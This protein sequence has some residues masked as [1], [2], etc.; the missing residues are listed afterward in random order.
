MSAVGRPEKLREHGTR[1]CCKFGPRPGGD[2][3]NGC[4]CERC[5]KANRDAESERRRLTAYG[6]WQPYIDAGPAR[7][8]LRAL[9]ASGI[10]WKQAARL[11]GVSTG[12]VS[13]ILYGG[14]GGRPPSRR[15]RPATAAAILSVVPS[16]AKLA[17]SSRVDATGTRRRVQALV[18]AGW[19]QSKISARLGMDRA[20]FGAVMRQD[21]VTAST[22][23]AVAALY[24]EL[25]DKGPPEQ[26]H[27]DKI[28]ASR[29]R[30]YS[31]ERG[32]PP[33]AAWDDDID[34]PMAVPAPDWDAPPALLNRLEIAAEGR[35]LLGFG[36][37]LEEAAR[38]LGTTPGRLKGAMA[39][40]PETGSAA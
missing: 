8:H 18:A 6:R 34:D 7:E 2:T 22:A 31:A 24:G 23:R 9:S 11:S 36:A 5:A 25:W 10:G 17:D 4:R 21:Q 37:S 14:P 30:R 35:H 15:V 13:K 1:A 39:R 38:R 33:P 19:S 28:A 26:G 12:A 40:Y 20:N 32:W 3:R 29:A 27:R 16:P